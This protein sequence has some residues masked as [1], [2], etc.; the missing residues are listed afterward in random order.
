MRKMLGW[1]VA[2]WIGVWLGTVC[3][4]AQ[5]GA[6]TMHTI[7]VRVL[8]GRTGQPVLPTNLLARVDKNKQIHSDWVSENDDATGFITLPA[9]AKLVSVEAVYDESMEIY[10][11][12][13]PAPEAYPGERHWYSIQTILRA[14]LVVPDGCG[15]K[16]HPIDKATAKPGE[17]IFYVRARKRGDPETN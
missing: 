15:K 1:R 13:D 4:I 16:R 7:T 8:D 11:N 3:A 14:G 12:C 6:P 10:V 5:A 9:T 2:L 17:L